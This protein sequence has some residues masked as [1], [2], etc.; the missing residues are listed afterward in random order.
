M[1]RVG[2]R[3]V[4]EAARQASWASLGPGNKLCHIVLDT[5]HPL[6]P[7]GGHREVIFFHL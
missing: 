1:L 4:V 3:F 7:E 6:G 2:L 5:A